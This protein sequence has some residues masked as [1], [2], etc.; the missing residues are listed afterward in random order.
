M[1]SEVVSGVSVEVK[2]YKD[3]PQDSLFVLGLPDVGLVGAIAVMQ[4]IRNL[5]MEEIGYIDSDVF[6]PIAL[7]RKGEP[8][9]PVRIFYSQTGNVLALASE[10]ALPVSALP[11]FSR[12][13]VDL[14]KKLRVKSLVLLGGVPV[15]NRL[16]IE[17]PKVYG[18][19]VL[20]SDREYLEKMGVELIEEGFVAGA[21]ALIMKECVKEGISCLA[22]LAESYLQYPDP[23]AAASVLEVFSKITGI[24]VDIEQLKSEAEELRL[25]LR[26]LMQRTMSALRE[27]QKSYEYTLPLMYV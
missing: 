22:L 14:A 18:I 7:I 17:K 19:G 25:K 10:V 3:V 23:G 12:S 9:R 4:L 13:I 20:S 5:N 1:S 8:K 21:Y 2:L 24:S 6:P 26:E 11:V 15:P 16:D 27:Q